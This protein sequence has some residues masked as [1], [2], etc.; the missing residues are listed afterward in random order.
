MSKYIME[1]RC[2]IT[3]SYTSF[4]EVAESICE[5]LFDVCGPFA[6]GAITVTIGGRDDNVDHEVTEARQSLQRAFAS[7]AVKHLYDLV[8]IQAGCDT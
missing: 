1:K 5:R 4:G 8:S 6:E 3:Y 7:E 2:S